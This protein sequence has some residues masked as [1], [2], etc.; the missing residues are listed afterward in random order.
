M[1][2]DTAMAVSCDLSKD[3]VR[4][5]GKGGDNSSIPASFAAV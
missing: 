2:V 1:M 5:I 3:H 4:R